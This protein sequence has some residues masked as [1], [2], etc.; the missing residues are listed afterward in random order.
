MFV[1]LISYSSFSLSSSWKEG[2]HNNNRKK[3]EEELLSEKK[4]GKYPY[5]YFNI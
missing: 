3:K 1:I 4:N 2:E 5:I